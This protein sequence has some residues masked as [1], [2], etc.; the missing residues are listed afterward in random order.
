MS[1]LERVSS[2]DI[3]RGNVADAV[4]VCEALTGEPILMAIDAVVGELVRALGGDGKVMLC[5]NGGSAAD[6][7]H[8]AAEFVGRFRL[9]RKALPAIS[10][11]DNMA[12]MTAIGNDYSYDDVFVRGVQAF[13]RPGD[14]LIG[15]S[16]SGTSE[17]V[18]RALG[19][20]NDA[21]L[22]TVAFVGGG[23]CPMTSL[24]KHAVAVEGAN[25]ARIQEG[26]ML[27]G[28]TIVEIVERELC[29]QS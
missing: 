5:G 24:A 11:A 17:N 13:G 2:A 14:V 12:G 8:L 7:Q 10:L 23:D 19:A 28:H 9:D 4:E 25:T 27:I 16:T 22:I 1:S 29:S 20:A 3:V 15:L 6:A 26:H 21:G 18:V